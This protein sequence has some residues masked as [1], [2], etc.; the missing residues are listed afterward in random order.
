MLNIMDAIKIARESYPNGKI[1]SHVSYRNVFL[2]QIFNDMPGE[3]EMDPFF[4]VDKLT[5]EFKE[6]SILTDGDTAEIVSLFEKVN[7]R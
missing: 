7:G 2:F 5:G 1:Q 4:S 3:E 6:F